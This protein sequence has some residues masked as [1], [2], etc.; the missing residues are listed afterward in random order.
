MALSNPQGNCQRGQPGQ[1]P[2]AR[3]D[4][5][6][7]SP[8]TRLPISPFPVDLEWLAGMLEEPA[9]YQSCRK[10][11]NLEKEPNPACDMMCVPA[12]GRCLWVA[13]VHIYQPYCCD[14]LLCSSSPHFTTSNSALCPP[15]L[16]SHLP[17]T[18]T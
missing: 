18:P 4:L 9:L 12:Y 3:M 2:G 10:N 6:R 13:L 5:G 1:E 16:L 17:P 14:N 15:P 7:G 11:K 8:L